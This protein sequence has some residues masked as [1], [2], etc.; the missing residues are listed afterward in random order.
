MSGTDTRRPE[1]KL[2]MQGPASALSCIISTSRLASLVE[3]TTSSS[4][5]RVGEEDAGGGR[6]EHVAA[7]VDEQLQEVDDV[8]VVD[9]VSAS[10]DEGL[11][12]AAAASRRSLRHLD[13]AR[14]RA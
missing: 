5:A 11:R 12:A 6:V 8:V 4:P 7:G 10:F 9:S 13:P 1:R 2:S 14:P 3:A